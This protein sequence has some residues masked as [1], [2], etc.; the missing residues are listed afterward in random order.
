MF[1][2]ITIEREYGCGGGAI[3]AQLADR[4]GWKLWDQLLT[5]EIARLANVDAAAVKRCDERMDSRFTAWP[6]LSG[7]AATNA[8]CVWATRPSTPTA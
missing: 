1:R 4:L 7:A 2:L 5:E 3:A 8:V 6:K